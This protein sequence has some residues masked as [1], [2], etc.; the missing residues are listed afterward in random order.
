VQSIE[1]RQGLM[2][3]CVEE[4][5][6]RLGWIDADTVSRLG[7]RMKNNQ[8]GQYLLRLITSDRPG[9]EV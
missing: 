6:F 3:A 7:H 4:I 9:V 1:E 2:M 8:Y 5:A